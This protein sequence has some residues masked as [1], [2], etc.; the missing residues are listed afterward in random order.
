MIQLSQIMGLIFD[1]FDNSPFWFPE[2]PH[3]FPFSLTVNEG[4]SLFTTLPTVHP[5]QDEI[6]SKSSVLY[7]SLIC[8]DGKHF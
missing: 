2:W 5:E 8:K 4:S 1:S 6:K 7:V 3:Q